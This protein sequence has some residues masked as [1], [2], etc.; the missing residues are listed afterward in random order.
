MGKEPT[1]D[2]TL[3]VGEIRHVV[4]FVNVAYIGKH[5][6]GVRH[7]LVNVVKVGQHQLSPSEKLIQRL[8]RSRLMAERLI[9]FTNEFDGIGNLYVRQAAE[10]IADSDIGRTP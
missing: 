3:F 1:D 9:E 10:Q 8:A 7:I 4:Q 6:V 2:C 5:T